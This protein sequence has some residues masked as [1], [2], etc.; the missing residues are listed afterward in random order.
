MKSIWAIP[1]DVKATPVQM[2]SLAALM[3]IDSREL[4]RK[5][6]DADREFVYLK[7]QI[8]PETAARVA[9]LGIPGIHQQ[10]EYRRYYPAARRWRRWSASPAWTTPARKASS[11]RTSRSWRAPRAAAG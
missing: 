5:L 8:P 2:K 1:E 11:S 9:A 10:N 4:A 6:S 3:Q 7:R